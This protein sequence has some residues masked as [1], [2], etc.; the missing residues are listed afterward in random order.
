L[1]GH[2]IRIRRDLLSAEKCPTPVSNQAQ[3][4]ERSGTGE[5]RYVLFRTGGTQR[6]IHRHPL[7]L[8]GHPFNAS[9]K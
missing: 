2:A 8:L 9:A 3:L 5:H 1:V 6:Q 4:A 7:L